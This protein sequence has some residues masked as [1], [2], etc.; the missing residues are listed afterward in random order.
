M[1]TYTHNHKA[2][3]WD[4]FKDNKYVCSFDT[5]REAADFCKYANGDWPAEEILKREG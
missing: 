4:V 1:Y 3:Q 2:Q 5:E